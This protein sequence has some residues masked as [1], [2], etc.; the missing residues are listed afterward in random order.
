L[1]QAIGDSEAVGKGAGDAIGRGGDAIGC[2]HFSYFEDVPKKALW[3]SK[4]IQLSQQPPFYCTT[5]S[6]GYQFLNSFRRQSYRQSLSALCPYRFTKSLSSLFST[7]LKRSKRA[8]K[9]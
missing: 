1:G 8:L 6:N 9:A 7:S 4:V 5:L 2:F 3:E